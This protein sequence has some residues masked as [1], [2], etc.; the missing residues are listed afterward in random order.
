MNELTFFGTIIV[1]IALSIAGG[2]TATSISWH[3]H[4]AEIITSCIDAG[5]Q[6]QHVANTTGEYE[7]VR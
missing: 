3:P 2:I 7:C 1:A 5:N 6:W 4:Q